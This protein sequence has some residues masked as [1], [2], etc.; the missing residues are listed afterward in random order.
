LILG[1]NPGFDADELYDE[2]ILTWPKANEYTNKSWKLATKLRSIFADAGL[3]NLLARSVGTNQLF[4]K[5]KGIDRHKT[6]LGWGGQSVG[7][8]EAA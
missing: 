2:E 7:C 5:S 3:K 8:T 6:G 1:R 4:F